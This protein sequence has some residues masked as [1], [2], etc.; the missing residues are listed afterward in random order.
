MGIWQNQKRNENGKVG[1]NGVEGKEEEEEK[2]GLG[3]VAMA[4]WG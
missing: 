2:E 1:R 3:E 4:F